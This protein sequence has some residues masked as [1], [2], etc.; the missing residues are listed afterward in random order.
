[1]AAP[2]GMGRG[3]TTRGIIRLFSRSPKSTILANCFSVTG[4]GSPPFSVYTICCRK[5][6]GCFLRC[7]VKQKISLCQSV[8]K[9]AAFCIKLQHSKLMQPFHNL[10]IRVLSGIDALPLQLNINEEIGE[11]QGVFAGSL[12]LLGK[13]ENVFQSIRELRSGND[14]TPDKSVFLPNNPSGNAT[15]GGNCLKR[16]K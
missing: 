15:A 7:T 4:M 5:I 9:T 14:R 16:S 6:L 2:A 3:L 10:F 8:R 12:M 1:M 13:R 11:C